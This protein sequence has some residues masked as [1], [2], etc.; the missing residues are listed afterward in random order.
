MLLRDPVETRP[1]TARFPADGADEREVM[2]RA[3]DTEAGER[4][5]VPIE[6]PARGAVRGTPDTRETPGVLGALKVRAADGTGPRTVEIC[7]APGEKLRGIIAAVTGAERSGVTEPA[8]F[9]DR[10]TIK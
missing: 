10:A 2:P 3:A 6:T 4:E 5:N 8:G 7:G 9:A 1:I